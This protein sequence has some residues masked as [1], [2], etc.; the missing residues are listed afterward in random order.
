[1]TKEPLKINLSSIQ[2]LKT[3]NALLDGEYTMN[4]LVEK[5]NEQE[6]ESIFNNS[7]ISKYINT[8]RYCG[9]DIPKVQNKYYIN[10]FPIGLSLDN[11]EI[12]MLQTLKD[13]ITEEMPKESC[14]KYQKLVDKLNRYADKKI[15]RVEKKTYISSFESFERAIREQKKVL[16]LLKNRLEIKGIPVTI[17]N[18]NGKM[19]FHVFCKNRI[20][21]ID[22]SRL[23]AI[24][25]TNE[26]F[27]GYMKEQNIVFILKGKLA[28]RYELREEETVI[29]SSEESVTVSNNSKNPEMLLLR[30]MRYDDLCEVYAPE[31]IRKQF[32]AIIDN[33]LKNYGIN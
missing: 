21:M 6:S 9:I 22:A 7:V 14:I 11:S 18:E 15:T 31:S 4:E 5:L 27:I 33:S 24:Q 25:V 13:F 3:L 17:S 26:S 12:E 10:K 29:S 20:R 23:S 30:L 28:K 8:C 2:V 16:L 32:K 19:F 1:M